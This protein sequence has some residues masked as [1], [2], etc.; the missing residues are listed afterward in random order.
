MKKIIV[1]LLLVLLVL[2][3]YPFN[4]K[5]VYNGIDIS[6]HNNICWECIAKDSNIKFCYIKAT[7]GGVIKD[8]KCKNNIE[9]ASKLNL[10][11]GLYHYFRTNISPNDQFNNFKSVYNK[12]NT[13]LIPVIDVEDHR[14]NYDN[15]SLVNK[16]LSELIELYY[17]EYGVYPI[18][19]LGSLNAIKTFPAIYKC[20]IWARTLDY[21]NF[22]PDFSIKQVSVSNIGCNYIDLNYSSNINKLKLKQ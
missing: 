10:N 21:S 17:N 15:I 9:N 12:F 3:F 11:I 4:V 1:C 6:H 5:R 18:I 16:R 2:W 14:N 7:E 20:K 19:Y 13:D 22:I 8:N